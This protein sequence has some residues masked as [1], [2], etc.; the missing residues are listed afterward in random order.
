MAIIKADDRGAAEGKLR[1][2]PLA[3]SGFVSW[4]L[5]ELFPCVEF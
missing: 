2:D 1:E 4:E 5:D 3:S